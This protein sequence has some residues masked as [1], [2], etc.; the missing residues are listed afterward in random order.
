[1]E[2]TIPKMTFRVE[3]LILIAII[4]FVLFGNVFYSTCIISKKEG[5]AVLEGVKHKINKLKDNQWKHPKKEAFTNLNSDYKQPF[6]FSSSHQAPIDTNKWFTS[7]LTYRAGASKN[8]SIQDILNR[9]KTQ[10]PLPEGEMLIFKDTSFKPECCVTSF[11]NSSG[12]ACI[13]VNSYKYLR[14]R[15]GNNVP[16]K[17]L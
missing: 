17:E 15:G 14:N 12:C 5:F 16:Y 4:S 9:R 2:I 11:S 3:I 6:P 8:K 7:N 13:D 10:L 1:M